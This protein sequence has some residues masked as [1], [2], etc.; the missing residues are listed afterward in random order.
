MSVRKTLLLFYLLAIVSLLGIGYYGI[1]L[2]KNLL[3]QEINERQHYSSMETLAFSSQVHFKKQVQEWKNILLRGGEKALYERYLRQFNEEETQT[4]ELINRL[5]KLL[6]SNSESVEIAKRFLSTH[7]V[8][9]HRYREALTAYPVAERDPHITVDRYVRGIDRRPTDLIDELVVSIRNEKAEA[10]DIL[11]KK[12]GQTARSLYIVVTIFSLLLI[13]AVAVT[14]NRVLVKP[15]LSASNIAKQISSGKLSNI[16]RYRDSENELDRLL[17][18]LDDMQQSLAKSAVKIAHQ[19]RT[20]QNALLEAQESERI[21]S[22]FITNLNHELVTP[23]T[24]VLGMLDLLEETAL[25]SEQREYVS[26]AQQSCERFLSTVRSVIDL[27]DITNQRLLI[28][29]VKFNLHDLLAK[30][31]KDYQHKFKAS[32]V[33]F[34][35]TY[36][37]SLP[38]WV[39]GDPRHIEKAADILLGNAIK[40]TQQGSIRFDTTLKALHDDEALVQ[41]EVGDTGKGIPAS[42]QAQIFGSFVQEDDS[43]ARAYEGLGLGLSVCQKIVELMGGTIS[44]HSTPGKGSTFTFSIPFATVSDDREASTATDRL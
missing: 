31:A 8:L 39:I 38:N 14:L 7:H 13:A 4:R 33:S 2:H 32:Q 20:L 23:M 27:S 44:V 11:E 19:N 12:A 43:T 40:F 18:S 37:R 10:L 41:F 9:G 30:I 16:V 35:S 36:D 24:G 29:A 28:N 1:H 3:N 34:S 26:L 5:I 42:Q 17:A 15:L 22:S 21:K 6:P 25:D